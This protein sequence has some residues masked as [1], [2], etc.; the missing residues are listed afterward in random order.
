[1]E[2]LG[3]IVREITLSNQLQLNSYRS[4]VEARIQ[5]E[6]SIRQSQVEYSRERNNLVTLADKGKRDGDGVLITKMTVYNL[7]LKHQ[8][9]IKKSMET[10]A[11]LQEL[12]LM[13]LGV[14][15]ARNIDFIDTEDVEEKEV[16]VSR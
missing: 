4:V 9:V 15:N 14:L 11:R 1:M 5:I 6:K 8:Q 3:T 2:K 16:M 7:N 10:L 12:E 13:M